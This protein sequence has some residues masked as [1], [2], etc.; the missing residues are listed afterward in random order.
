MFQVIN[1][2]ATKI[3]TKIKYTPP[4]FLRRDHAG[5]IFAY[6]LLIS[7]ARRITEGL[8]SMVDFLKSVT[9]GLAYFVIQG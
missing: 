8:Y 1:A 4:T 6:S 2:V 9:L 3:E 5:G 7:V